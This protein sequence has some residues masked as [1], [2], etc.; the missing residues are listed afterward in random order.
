MATFTGNFGD[1]LV[2]GFNKIID[3]TAYGRKDSVY[4][5][6][7]NI[8]DSTRPT[9]TFSEITGFG[10]MEVKTEGGAVA[11][12]DPLQ[13]FDT[14]F[15]HVEYAKA[16][17]VTEIMVEDDQYAKIRMLP[18]QLGLSADE[19]I[20]T[21]AANTYNNGFTSGTGGDGVYLYSASHPLV[22]GGNMSNIPSAHADLSATSYE[23]ALIDIAAWTDHRGKKIRA[24]PAKLM[25]HNANA[26]TVEK[27]FGSDKD[28]DSAN[29]AVNPAASR[30][31]EMIENP[32]LTDT[33][34]WHIQCNMHGMIFFWRRRIRRG[35]DNDFNTGNLRYK[36][37]F[38]A[39][40][41]WHHPFG[42]Y[43]ST[44]A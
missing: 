19:T 32:Y 27:L 2:Q 22:G 6:L 1:L 30:K 35:R 31:L 18:E 20:E 8:M 40:N 44:G 7:Y 3:E 23:Q 11:Y 41:G 42:S 24:R 29:N 5:R 33:D 10:L 4:K 36:L 12:D 16:F 38:R 25:Y 39:S 43:G 37:D 26:W 14:T 34:S 21:L 17:E 28:P 13:G 9:E 15:T